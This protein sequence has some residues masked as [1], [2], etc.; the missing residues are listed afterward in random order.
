MNRPPSRSLLDER[1]VFVNGR[2][3]WMAKHLL[4]N[5]DL[6]EVLPD[7]FAAKTEKSAP[8]RLLLDD[9]LFLVADKPPRLLTNG[10]KSLETRLRD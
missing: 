2:R 10:E 1:M 9:P 8:V 6:V 5:R 4:Q 3:I 7:A